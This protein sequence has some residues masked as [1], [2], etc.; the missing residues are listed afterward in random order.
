ML[1]TCVMPHTHS[2][3]NRSEIVARVTIGKSN[4]EK[5]L[6]FENLELAIGLRGQDQQKPLLF[7]DILRPAEM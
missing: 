5:V 2:T 6:D 4:A 7:P 3:L 1:G